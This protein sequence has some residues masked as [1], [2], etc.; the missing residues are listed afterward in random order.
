MHTFVNDDIMDVM[1]IIHFQLFWR[2]RMDRLKRFINDK[3]ISVD[4]KHSMHLQNVNVH[5]WTGSQ[6]PTANF[7]IYIQYIRAKRALF[8]NVGLHMR[9][10]P[11]L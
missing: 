4:G 1:L 9:A 10:F 11:L 8:E 6:E 2:L 7:M 5:V 3:W